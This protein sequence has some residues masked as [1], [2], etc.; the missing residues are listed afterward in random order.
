[1]MTNKVVI[2]PACTDLNRG[3]QALVWEAAYLLKH[4]INE[5]V[6]IS[7]VD[8]GNT[9]EDRERQSR[10]T[11]SA[12][13]KVFRNIVENPKRIISE[14]TVHSSKF[15]IILA[16]LLAVVDFI[17]HFLVLCLPFELLFK[18]LFP[19][20]EHQKTFRVIKNSDSIVVKGG[21]FLH[22][23]GKVEDLYYLWFGLYYL[24]LGK[25]L[26]KK[27]IVLPNSIGPITGFSNR[28]FTR[29]VLNKCDLLYVRERVSLDFC[30]KIGINNAKYAFD[31]GY[32]AEESLPTALNKELVN[33]C[34]NKLS[35]EKTNIGITVRP[36]RFPSAENPTERYEN[37]INSIATFCNKNKENSAYHFI[38]QVQG[39][40]AHETDMIAINDVISKLESDVEYTVI[41]IDINYKE[42]MT[43]YSKFDLLLGT[44]FHSVI[45]SQVQ[46]VPA[47]A[48]AYGGNKTHGIMKEINLDEYVIDIN[49]ITAPD[50]QAIFTKLIKNTSE[51][52]AKLEI[53]FK[54]I[55]NDRESVSEDLKRVML[56]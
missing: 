30:H 31:L 4:A 5:K 28:L 38:V 54:S 21:G 50:L 24:L 49:E 56:K 19:N 52:K 11:K 36:Y 16:G 33:D 44:R 7:I 53:A 51:Y 37:Y 35:K 9:D 14:S 32:Y 22:T 17:R 43:V 25:R 2:V 13:F 3:D 42:I 20:K 12:G 46:G 6:D 47:A 55:E 41:D 1:M 40:S 8:Y 29:W 48:I 15:G 45:F 18:L 39:P 34:I 10:Q 27:L 23:Y 26:N